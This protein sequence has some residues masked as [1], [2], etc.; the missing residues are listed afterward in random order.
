MRLPMGAFDVAA[1]IGHSDECRR[2]MS[3]IQK[4]DAAVLELYSDNEVKFLVLCVSCPRPVAADV[5]VMF[6][7]S[8]ETSLDLGMV[9]ISPGP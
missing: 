8:H 6:P 2:A 5:V 3:S 1:E 4:V 9:W 7:F